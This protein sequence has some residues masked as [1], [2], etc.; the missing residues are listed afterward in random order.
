MHPP[1]L[2]CC[3]GIDPLLMLYKALGDNYCDKMFCEVQCHCKREKQGGKH[4]YIPFFRFSL[5]AF[6]MM[7]V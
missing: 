5:G 6:A 7:I 2:K 3:G 4:G 1:Q